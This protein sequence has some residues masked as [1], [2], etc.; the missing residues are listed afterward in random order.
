[1][2][3]ELLK[4]LPGPPRSL[5]RAREPLGTPLWGG[6]GIFSGGETVVINM[7]MVVKCM[8]AAQRVQMT[9]FSCAR[10]SLAAGQLFLNTD[11]AQALVRAQLAI[12]VTPQME[13][14][15][16]VVGP[17]LWWLRWG[18]GSGKGRASSAHMLN[19]SGGSST[20]SHP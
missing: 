8:T 4:T 14:V 6:F 11:D 2:K 16:A 12:S 5:Q 9:K 17:G 7:A 20:G 1:M 15:E 18:V 13:D 19:P 10:H 3:R